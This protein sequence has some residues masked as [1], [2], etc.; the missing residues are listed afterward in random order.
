M[1]SPCGNIN[2]SPSIHP[3]RPS[4]VRDAGQYWLS[5]WWWCCFCCCFC[6]CLLPPF[7]WSML[8][9]LFNHVQ[10]TRQQP[11]KAKNIDINIRFSFLQSPFFP[12]FPFTRRIHIIESSIQNECVSVSG[13]V[14]FPGGCG[15][16]HSPGRILIVLIVVVDHTHRGDHHTTQLIQP[17][18]SELGR[19]P[20]L[21]TNIVASALRAQCQS[22][23]ES[24]HATWTVARSIAAKFALLRD[25]QPWP[26]QVHRPTPV[27]TGH[28]RG[29][30]TVQQDLLP[31]AD[32]LDQEG[33]HQGESHVHQAPVL[34][35]LESW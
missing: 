13:S 35:L 27:H 31:L 16:C 6:W 4:R 1:C 11:G 2:Q 29:H 26:H 33:L 10:H 9:L 14:A 30:H 5:E 23:R 19:W 20:P 7:V 25:G 3:V 32:Q 12:C 24:A 22:V 21:S 34:W 8:L 18:A 15:T 17:L 28:Q